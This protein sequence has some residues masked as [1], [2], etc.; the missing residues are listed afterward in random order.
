[1]NPIFPASF[2]AFVYIALHAQIPLLGYI[3]WIEAGASVFG[4]VL[5]FF[6]KGDR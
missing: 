5:P 2:V 4:A 6:E 3:A 1:M